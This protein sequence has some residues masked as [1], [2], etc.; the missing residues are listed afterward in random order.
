M[1]TGAWLLIGIGCALVI[2][3]V[4]AVFVIPSGRRRQP[5]SVTPR[6]LTMPRFTI[7]SGSPTG[8][9]LKGF[10]YLYAPLRYPRVHYSVV[11]RM[12][13]AIAR[14]DAVDP[15]VVPERF[16]QA[17]QQMVDLDSPTGAP[18]EGG[19]PVVDIFDQPRSEEQ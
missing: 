8:S 19:E 10:S 1:A 5:L 12:D 16:G 17:L 13:R 14:I 3:T 11:G 2:I 7:P 9:L 6:R 18:A 15:S 4:L